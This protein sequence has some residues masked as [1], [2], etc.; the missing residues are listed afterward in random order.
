MSR[1]KHTVWG[2]CLQPARAHRGVY[3][4][5]V[6]LTG[7]TASTVDVHRRWLCHVSVVTSSFDH[8]LNCRS[9][10]GRDAAAAAAA[11]SDADDD[12]DAA[13]A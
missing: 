7:D 12:A 2:A 10:S 5:K 13:A 8:Q 1:G 6:V 9:G 11:A 4:D 3:C